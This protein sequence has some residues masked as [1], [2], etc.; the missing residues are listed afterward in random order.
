V[1]KVLLDTNALAEAVRPRPNAGFLRRLR[2]NEARLAIAAV[3]LHE[4][5]FGVERLPDGKRKELLREYLRDVVTKLPALPY[6]AKAAAWHASERAKLEAA[7]RPMPYAD[8]QIAAIAVVNG[9][10]LVTS[11]MRDFRHVTALR[12]EDWCA[13]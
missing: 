9:L 12:V 10:T 7:S 13:P 3:T 4:A 8:G 2:A 1:V 5:L 11:N 6:D